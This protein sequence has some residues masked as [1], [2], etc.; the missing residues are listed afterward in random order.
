MMSS[1][2]PTVLGLSLGDRLLFMI[3]APGLG[4]V[5]GYFIPRIADWATTLPWMPFEGP[6]RL[7]ASFDG[8]WGAVG[9]LVGG[10]A[11]G[12]FA[13]AAVITMTLKVTLTDTEI[14]LSKDDKTRTIARSDVGVVFIDGKKLVILDGE[15]RE[16]AREEYEASADDVERAFQSHGY[17]WVSEDPHADLFRRWVPDHPDLPG[18]VNA[19]L[20]AREIALTKKAADD[21]ADLRTE[22]QKLGFV[23]RDEG[24]RQYVRPLV[25]S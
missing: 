19:V 9:L 25:R 12:V 11:L 5:L 21:A 17:P 10:L 23:V 14:Q 6:L 20:R 16:L 2:E 22:V 8:F 7:I 15:S 24:L 13:A 18:A 1:R 3:G 4:L